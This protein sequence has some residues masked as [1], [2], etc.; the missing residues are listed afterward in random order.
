MVFEYRTRV[1]YSDTDA[2]AIVY[3]THYLDWAEHA[4]TEML[5]T[6]LPDMKQSS[7]TDSGFVFVVKSINIEYFTPAVLDDEI[8]VYTSIEKLEVFSAKI[9]QIIKRGDIVLAD[10]LVKVAF[11]SK[12]TKKPQKLPDEIKSVLSL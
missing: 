10:I 4:R 9:R 6:L 2:G 3:H 8:C 1:Y 12:K 5:R 11:I 7:L